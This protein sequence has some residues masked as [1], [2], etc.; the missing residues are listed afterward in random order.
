[1]KATG[2]LTH[3]LSAPSTYEAVGPDEEAQGGG[4]RRTFDEVEPLRQASLEFGSSMSP[5]PRET[6]GLMF[7]GDVAE[8][9]EV[10]SHVLD[11]SWVLHCSRASCTGHKGVIVLCSQ[12]V[13]RRSPRSSSAHQG[14]AMNL[15]NRFAGVATDEAPGGQFLLGQYSSVDS[16]AGSHRRFQSCKGVYKE[17][18][19]IVAFPFQLQVQ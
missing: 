9:V 3:R 18:S 8:S 6:A 5:D 12:Y 19:N 7:T 13:R 11:H 10:Q 14:A 15:H 2:V 17:V 16:T 1:M 4:G